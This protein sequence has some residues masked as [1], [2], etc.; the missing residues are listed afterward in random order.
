MDKYSGRSSWAGPEK[1][2]RGEEPE[3]V[4]QTQSWERQGGGK[5]LK[6]RAIWEVLIVSDPPP[7][8]SNIRE[9]AM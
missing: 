7:Q 3:D 1:G 8:A 9:G 4:C 6:V 2:R 5:K